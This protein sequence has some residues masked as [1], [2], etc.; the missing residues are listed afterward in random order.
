MS[1]PIESSAAS[2]LP[3]PEN[4]LHAEAHTGNADPAAQAHEDRLAARLH[5]LHDVGVEANRGHRH[6]DEEL[7]QRL[8]GRS[9]RHGKREHGGDD[10]RQYKEQDEEREDLLDVKRT[11]GSAGAL[12][13]LGGALGLTDLPKREEQRD[14]DDRKCAGELDDGGM[15]QRIGARV[16]AVPGSCGGGDG[17]RVVH[18]R[19]G[20]QAKA[21]VA[22]AEHGAERGEN[23]CSDDVE[24]EDDADGLGDL[25]VVRIDDRRSG[26]NCG[27]AADR[28]AHT[29]ERRDL[30]GDV[31]RAAQ[32]ERDDQRRGDGRDDDGQGAG[33]HLGDFA[34]VEAE[35]QQDHRVLQDL[36]R[37]VLDAR[38]GRL[39][40]AGAATQHQAERHADEDG[41]HRTA[42]DLELLAEQPC[43]HRDDQCERDA[44]PQILE[45][46]KELHAS[47]LSSYLR[48]RWGLGRT[49]SGVQPRSPK[50]RPIPSGSGAVHPCAAYDDCQNNGRE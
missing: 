1:P 40:H 26:G 49:H 34:Q 36:L 17:R 8:D 15:I 24:E 42:D 5:Q 33:A 35:A 21:L 29:H 23:Q 39:H 45:I 3:N 28:G 50:A 19:A 32:H 30:L 14:G 18:S 13:R 44:A 7:R 22:H 4:A 27:A 20:E 43:R 6:H 10:A 31:Q 47:N 11:C 46:L 12:A 2:L 38:R 25:L 16:H 48:S 9:H 41:E 37:R